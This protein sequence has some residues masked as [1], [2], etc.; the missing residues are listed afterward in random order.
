MTLSKLLTWFIRVYKDLT[1]PLRQN[2][3]IFL[4]SL[5]TRIFSA[6]KTRVFSMI[7]GG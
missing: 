7:C 5:I 1:E 2:M 3:W 6:G 4:C